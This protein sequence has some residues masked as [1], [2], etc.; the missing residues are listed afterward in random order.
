[1]SREK[2]EDDVIKFEG[3]RVYSL[4]LHLMCQGYLM[5]HGEMESPIELTE[6]DG[7]TTE[8]AEWWIGPFEGMETLEGAYSRFEEEWGGKVAE[9]VRR[10]L[11]LIFDNSPVC[12]TQ[13]VV[14]AQ[15]DLTEILE[16]GEISVD[17]Q[18]GE[19]SEI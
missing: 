15:R 19:S 8:K 9:S 11:K 17:V 16:G 14:E 1:M 13:L 5:T 18:V 6:N 3:V 10:L 12:D 2:M 4:S 7:S